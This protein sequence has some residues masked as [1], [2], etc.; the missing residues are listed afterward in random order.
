[1]ES[2]AADMQIR[3]RYKMPDSRQSTTSTTKRLRVGREAWGEA[4]SV[5]SVE[6]DG[7]DRS[8]ATGVGAVRD[9]P[10]RRATRAGTAP[11][12]EVDYHPDR[13]MR[14]GGPVQG[15]GAT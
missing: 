4:P 2:R 15:G 5:S 13:S 9:S 1:M 3:S 12:A 6:R 11:V 10:S 14:H 7:M 8:I